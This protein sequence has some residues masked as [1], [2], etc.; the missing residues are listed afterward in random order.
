RTRRGGGALARRPP[1]RAAGDQALL[2]GSEG[3]AARLPEP[4]L[5]A[6]PPPL[7][8]R[9]HRSLALQA[10]GIERR[11]AR[12]TVEGAR[13]GGATARTL[14]ADAAPAAVRR[15]QAARRDRPGVRR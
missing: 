15:S 14:P 4:R 13:R 3:A 5:R 11:G 7:G 8:A 2:R 9:A 6:Q 12:V 10:G 1:T